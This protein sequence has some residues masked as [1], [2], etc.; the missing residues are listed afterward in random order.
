LGPLGTAATNRPIIGLYVF[1]RD[2]RHITKVT[3]AMRGHERS[4]CWFR[5]PNKRSAA[6]RVSARVIRAVGYA[7]EA[8]LFGSC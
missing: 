8:P 7:A 6:I 1:S 5:A 2:F 4:L 3:G